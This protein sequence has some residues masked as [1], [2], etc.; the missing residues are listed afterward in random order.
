MVQCLE[1]E[2][3]RVLINIGDCTQTHDSRG[4][5]PRIII[6]HERPGAG[7]RA[8]DIRKSRTQHSGIGPNNRIIV[9]KFLN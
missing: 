6:V 1:Q 2:A 8:L 3:Q 4:L 5:N 7:Q 9:T